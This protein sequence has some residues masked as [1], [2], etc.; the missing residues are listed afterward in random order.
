MTAVRYFAAI[1]VAILPSAALK[2]RSEEDHKSTLHETTPSATICEARTIN[3]I[4][5]SLPQLCLTSTWTRSTTTH[6]ASTSTE[7]TLDLMEEATLTTTPSS[8]GH[9][10]HTT[11]SREHTEIETQASEP[12]TSPFLSFE[13][14]KEMMLRRTGQDPQELRSRKRPG[15]HQREREPPDLGHFGLGEEDE[16][17]LDFEQYLETSASKKATPSQHSDHGVV[18]HHQGDEIA[19]EGDKASIHRSKDA[20]KTCKE[21]FSSSSFD[22]GATILKTGRGTK[23]AKAILVENKDSYMLLECAVENKFVIVE[24]SDDTLIDTMV[25]ANFEFFSS[26]I[27]HFRV[28]VSD[29]Y[30]VKMDRWKDIGT[31]EAR[32][33]RDIQAFLVE[34]PQIW[35]KYVRIEFLTQ[36]GNEFYCPVSLLRVHGSRMLDSWKDHE[37]GGEIDGLLEGEIEANTIAE[38]PYAEELD[39]GDSRSQEDENVAKN[40]TAWLPSDVAIFYPLHDICRTDSPMNNTNTSKEEKIGSDHDDRYSTQKV[41]RN[42]P[43]PI[44]AKPSKQH[45]PDDKEHS[46]TSETNTTASISSAADARQ[47]TQSSYPAGSSTANETY[48]DSSSSI[49]AKVST[50]ASSSMKHRTSGT[51]SSSSASPTVQEGFFNAI[52]KRLHHVETNLSLSL[53][54]LDDHSRY[55]QEAFQKAEQKQMSKVTAFLQHLNQTVLDE[56]RGVRDQYEQIWQSTVIALETQKEQSDRDIVA[57]GARLNLLADEVVFQKR[58]AIVQA[59]LLLCCLFLV[60]FSRGVPIPYLAPLLDQSTTTTSHASS[61]APRVRSSEPFSSDSHGSRP[62]GLQGKLPFEDFPRDIHT[63]S[64]SAIEHSF[65]DDSITEGFASTESNE[66]HAS[67]VRDVDVRKNSLSPPLTPSSFIED[68]VDDV[69]PAEYEIQPPSTRRHPAFAH[70]YVRKP[71]PALPEYPSP[72]R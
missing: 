56:L 58:M 35:A 69:V 30:P 40:F 4:T 70:G 57:L 9:T 17:S 27:R 46:T 36:Y 3:Y 71:L 28:S 67:G 14:W 12:E 34:N 60:I 8:D 7:A 21:R 47:T 13:D 54:Y 18:G 5:H 59:V 50:P 1:L 29:R 55:M 64:G 49:T 31:F 38:A 48:A 33:S 51:Q 2:D 63:K 20:G 24:L 68:S 23:N 32:N 52:T 22:A 11:D 25:L 42:E 43:R 62:D 16:I 53:Q 10:T 37:T 19:Y 26:M 6:D 41:W 61:R 15:E 65:L 72:E 45:N 66:V 39:H 44:M